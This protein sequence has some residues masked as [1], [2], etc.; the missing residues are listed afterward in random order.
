MPILL[1]LDS[2]SRALSLALYDGQTVLAELTWMTANNHSVEL[3]PALNDILRLGGLTVESLSAIAVS[4]GP[5]SFNGLR[6]GVS[7]AKGLALARDLPLIGVRTLDIV[8]AAQPALP[9]GLLIA[10]VAAGRGR[11]AAC[12]YHGVD[13]TWHS[14][15]NTHIADWAGVLAALPP[16]HGPICAA[17][18]IDPLGRVAL[19]AANIRVS[20]AAGNLRRAG[21]LAEIAWLAWQAGGTFTPDSVQP[22]YLHQP[23]VPHP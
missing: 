1:A 21:Y 7:T 15:E 14:D 8:A 17:G 3:A 6:I 16:H 4:L 13:G 19:E 11:V 20:G 9:D 22:F 10:A 23:G 2:A 5:G 18:E 12:T